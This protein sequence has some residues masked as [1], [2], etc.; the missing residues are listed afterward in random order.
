MLKGGL[1]P[2]QDGKFKLC[3]ESTKV[4]FSHIGGISARKKKKK[5]LLF[6]CSTKLKDHV[7]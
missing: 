3:E 1:G 7:P 6:D 2:S 4:Y 5:N